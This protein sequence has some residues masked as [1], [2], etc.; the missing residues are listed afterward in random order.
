MSADDSLKQRRILQAEK[1]RAKR[2]ELLAS[3]GYKQQLRERKE[4]KI[5]DALNNKYNTK[6]VNVLLEE[7]IKQRNEADKGLIEML[8]KINTSNTQV[9]EN[10]T[11]SEFSDANILKSKKNNSFLE[12]KNAK[13]SVE[14]KTK[15]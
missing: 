8:N 2:M 9:V 5:M 6:S 10:T 12:K 3:D 15:K 7:V 13:N 14:T 1:A 11:D 4:K